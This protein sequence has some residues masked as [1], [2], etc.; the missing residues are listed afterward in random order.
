[1]SE[2]YQRLL[3]SLTIV[4]AVYVFSALFPVLYSAVFKLIIHLDPLTFQQYAIYAA[5]TILIQTSCAPFIYYMRS[6]E[7]RT[8]FRRILCRTHDRVETVLTGANHV[9]ISPRA[10]TQQ[11][12]PTNTTAMTAFEKRL[13]I[14]SERRRKLTTGDIEV[15]PSVQS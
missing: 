7:Y 8:A 2:E 11:L 10:N 9:A 14:F 15:L 12:Q 13:S 5:W 3:T 1:M 4:A 6:R